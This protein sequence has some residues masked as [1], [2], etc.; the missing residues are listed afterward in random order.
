MVLAVPG[1]PGPG[2]EVDRCLSGSLVALGRG[3]GLRSPRRRRWHRTRARKHWDRE[4][5]GQSSTRRDT[6][7][8]L[9][10]MDPTARF[11]AFGDSLT[12]GYHTNGLAFSPYADALAAAIGVPTAA[13]TVCGASG[14][15][16]TQLV[17]V[18][19]SESERD[20]CG[21]EYIGLK[22]LCQR[23]AQSKQYDAALIMVTLPQ[24]RR[25]PRARV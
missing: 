4:E 21:K 8:T 14:L 3:G 13:V 19:E 16:A 15:Q 5:E 11:L 7:R 18:L 20:V 12:A 2:S 6:G 10:S 23:A 17:H 1:H 24:P 25:C 9:L 22:V